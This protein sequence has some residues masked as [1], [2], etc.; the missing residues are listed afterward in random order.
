MDELSQIRYMCVITV[1]IIEYY[2]H[3]T[4]SRMT[5]LIIM[6]KVATNQY[7]YRIIC[8]QLHIRIKSIYYL[9]TL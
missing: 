2:Q 4:V 7:H 9:N 1:Q 3:S 8:F 6:P 5:L